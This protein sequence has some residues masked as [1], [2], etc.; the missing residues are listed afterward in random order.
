MKMF[1][2][3]STPVIFMLNILTDLLL[4]L[5]ATDAF[6]IFADHVKKRY[7]ADPGFITMNLPR[8]LDALDAA[9]VDNPVVC[10]SIN[11]LG[12]RMSGG[13]RAYEQAIATR[14]FR[15]VAMGVLASGGIDAR[16]AIEY[17]ASQPRIE[18]ILFGAS[19]ASHIRQTKQ[20]IEELDRAAPAQ[21]QANAG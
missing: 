9:G 14:R 6:R 12:F 11:K 18:S 2:G 1:E 16:E 15:P 10:S 4:G 19:S 20:L 8:T 21:G 7:G 13:I 3:L 17:I 5:G